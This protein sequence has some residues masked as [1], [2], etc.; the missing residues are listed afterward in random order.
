M[1]DV[2]TLLLILHIHIKQ[3]AIWVTC[4]P[5]SFKD[6]YCEEMVDKRCVRLLMHSH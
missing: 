1:S 6:Q 4:S 5:G 2:R 3:G